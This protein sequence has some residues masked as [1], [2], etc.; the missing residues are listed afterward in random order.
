[1]EIREA[2][3]TSL[4][5]LINIANKDDAYILKKMSITLILRNK[6]IRS[7]LKVGDFVFAFICKLSFL[8]YYNMT[9]DVQWKNYTVLKLHAKNL[10]K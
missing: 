9:D 6:A 2:I 3:K 4:L 7:Y 10:E 5:N 8:S 1:M